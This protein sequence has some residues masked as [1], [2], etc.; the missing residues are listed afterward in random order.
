MTTV[1][2][3]YEFASTYSYPTAMRI[4]RLAKNA[5]V[6]LAWCPFLLGPSTFW[7]RLTEIHGCPALRPGMTR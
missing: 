2:F 1:E 6:A 4:E 7:R 5:G 3:W